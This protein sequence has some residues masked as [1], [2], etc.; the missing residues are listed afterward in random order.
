MRDT[1][2]NRRNFN[3]RG[4]EEERY[5]STPNMAEQDHNQKGDYFQN[6]R[7]YKNYDNNK[8]CGNYRDQSR[9]IFMGNNILS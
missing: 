7:R 3:E 2:A 4:S 6:V 9:N 8:Y 5:L 1:F